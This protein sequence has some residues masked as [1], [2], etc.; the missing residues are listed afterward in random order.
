MYWTARAPQRYWRWASP[1]HRH[2]RVKRLRAA[3]VGGPLL[4][5]LSRHLQERHM[6]EEYTR[7]QSSHHKI[8]TGVLPGGVLGPL[9]W[10][11]FISDLN[12]VPSARAF[13]EDITDSS[14]YPGGGR[15]CDIPPQ[16]HP[17]PH[18][19]LGTHMSGQFCRTKIQLL[20]MSGS[21]CDARP[22]FTNVALPPQTRNKDPWGHI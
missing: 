20:V 6:R 17:P 1:V 16:H 14:L 22:T 9:L 4:K 11:I 15:F 5:L 21:N 13:V 18:R 10:K 3:S 8:E 7:Q 19:G 12:F 2:S